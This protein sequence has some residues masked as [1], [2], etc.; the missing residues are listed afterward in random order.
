VA[1]WLSTKAFD[2]L[3]SALDVLLP[4]TGEFPSASAA[5]VATYIDGFLGAFSVTPPLIWAKGP[6]SGRF[7]GAPAFSTFHQLSN[8]DELAWRTRIEGSQGIEARE[9]NG[10]VIG[11]QERYQQGLA[12]LGDAFSTLSLL[13][14][15]ARLR[16]NPEFL[17]LLYSHACEG[18]YGAPEYGGNAEKKGWKAIDFAGDVQPRGWSDDEV[19][20]P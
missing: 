3:K 5:N 20:L 16:D 13:E 10:P 17:E 11:L 18:M 15:K 6:T 19:A 8:L 2:T 7:G 1:R 9:F 14:K 4:G 12:A